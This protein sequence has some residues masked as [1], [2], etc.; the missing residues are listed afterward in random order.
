VF[1]VIS[2]V[3]PREYA[4]LRVDRADMILHRV[5]LRYGARDINAGRLRRRGAETS[6]LSATRQ[7]A[8]SF[9]PSI[10]HMDADWRDVKDRIRLANSVDNALKQARGHTDWFHRSS[11]CHSMQDSR[12]HPLCSN[13]G[14]VLATFGHSPPN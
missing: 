4:H 2:E 9:G 8:D 10:N 7:A 13:A 11:M 5:A 6:V 1:K 14:I 3:L 12:R